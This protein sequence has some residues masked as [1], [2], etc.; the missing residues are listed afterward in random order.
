MKVELIAITPD[1][2]K[3]IEYAA[4]VC[5]DTTDNM[6]KGDLISALLKSGHLSPFEHA[7]ATFHI[8]GISRACSHQLVRHRIAS[9]SQRSQRYVEENGFGYVTPDSIADH[10]GSHRALGLMAKAIATAE[11]VYRELRA[12]GIPRED[13]RFVLPNACCTELV[14]TANFRELLHIFELRISPRA[15]WEIRRLCLEMLRLL[16]YEAP[17]VF[18]PL[19]DRLAD[20]Y[21]LKDWR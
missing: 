11:Q 14:M 12:C 13:A 4:R 9:Y 6:G 19:R 3:L 18:G 21:S 1:P 10:S 2:E 16:L 7:S 20:K 5:Y 17:K 15:Q 8:Q